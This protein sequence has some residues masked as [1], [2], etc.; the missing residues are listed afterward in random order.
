VNLRSGAIA[1]ALATS[2][3]MFVPALPANAV[4]CNSVAYACTDLGYAGSSGG[5]SY[6]SFGNQ[7]SA[8]Y[9]HNCTAYIGWIL[10]NTLPYHSQF[11]LLGNARDWA[12]R[13]GQLGSLGVRV[14]TTPKIYSVAQWVGYN[15]VAYV[16]AV[17]T[18]ASGSVTSI[19]ISEDNLKG[20]TSRRTIAPNDAAW[21]DSFIDFGITSS[22]GGGSGGGGK[23]P[24]MLVTTPPPLN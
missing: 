20:D 5:Y 8:G 23:P 15:H 11:N 1:V 12:N 2:T 4:S 17:N 24:V 16:T 7:N 19:D 10:W 22:Y 3:V 6:A 9:W 14:S 13:A 21:P 18:N